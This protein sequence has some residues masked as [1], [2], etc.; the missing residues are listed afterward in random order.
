VPKIQFKILEILLSPTSGREVRAERR[1]RK[2]E[3]K[4]TLLI[5]ATRFAMQPVYNAGRAVH[6]LCADQ[7]SIGCITVMKC[8]G[9]EIIWESGW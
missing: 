4:I 9:G 3:E 8:D 2:K 6:A 5:E 1:E 7:Y